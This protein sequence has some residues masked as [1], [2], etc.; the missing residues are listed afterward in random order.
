[1][2]KAFKNFPAHEVR[3]DSENNPIEVNP[4][5]LVGFCTTKDLWSNLGLMNTNAFVKKKNQTGIL[6]L[7]EKRNI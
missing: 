1:L 6:Y 3:I 4:Y 7:K 2:V 5:D